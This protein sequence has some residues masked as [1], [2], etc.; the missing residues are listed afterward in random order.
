[1]KKRQ[2]NIF[3]KKAEPIELKVSKSNLEKKISIPTSNLS[4]CTCGAASAGTEIGLSMHFEPIA[5]SLKLH[6]H[7]FA[8]LS[9]QKWT[10]TSWEN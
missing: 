6:F 7:K 10:T 5:T 9:D 8:F 2:E 3:F 1:M 4:K